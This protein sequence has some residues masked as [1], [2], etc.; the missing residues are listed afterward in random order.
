MA[1][2]IQSYEQQYSVL[3][4]D[5]T[6]KIGRLKIATEENRDQL[7]KEIQSNFEEA[8]D[9]LEQLEL[10]CRGS[11]AGSRVEAYRAELKRVRDEYR[12]VLTNSATYNMDTEESF[13]DWG[14]ANEQRQKLLDNTERLERTGK[15]LTEGYRVVLET[16]QIGAAVLQ[17]LSGQRETLQRSRGRLRETDEQLNRSSRLINSMMVRALQ[18]RFILVMVFLVVGV[19]LCLGLYFYVT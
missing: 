3:T 10:E 8:N 12:S 14:G 9:L 5:I 11:G 16:E 6:A 13:D 4:A 7:S 2:L 15:T 17:D 18:D 1:T 19:L